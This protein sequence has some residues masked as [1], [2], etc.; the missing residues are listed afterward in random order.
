MDTSKLN[1]RITFTEHLTANGLLMFIDTLTECKVPYIA[2]ASLRE[3]FYLAVTPSEMVNLAD[4]LRS[5]GFKFEV[6]DYT[7]IAW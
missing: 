2:H 3:T 4:I 7:E 5:Y 1:T 6:F